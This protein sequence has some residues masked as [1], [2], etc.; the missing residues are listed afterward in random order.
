MR[1]FMKLLTITQT[2]KQTNPPIMVAISNISKFS[3]QPS[4]R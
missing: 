3:L 1:T 4:K 2:W